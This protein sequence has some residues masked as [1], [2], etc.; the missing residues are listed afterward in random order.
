MKYFYKDLT[1][2]VT[3]SVYMPKEDSELLAK[4]IEDMNI[5]NKNC[6][7]IGCGSGLLSIIM[8]KRGAFVM[9]IDTN[10]EAVT[11]AKRNAEQNKVKINAFVS[12]MFENV[13]GTYDMI[14]FNPP[15]LPVDDWETD[16]T[17]AGG[18]T[19]RDIIERFIKDVKSY[20]NP[21]GVVLLLISSLTGEEEV[22]EMFKKHGMK[23]RVAARQK[24]PWEELIVLESK[25]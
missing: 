21:D 23:T 4:C 14:V 13:K 11:A 2:D 5:Y 17:Y 25:N 3:E 12:D 9:A 18:K 20:L 15:Y 8:V 7:E 19:G 10:S 22:L 16:A 1:L 24:I 6:L